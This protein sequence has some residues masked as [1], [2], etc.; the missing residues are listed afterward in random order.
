LFGEGAD[1]TEVPDGGYGRVLAA[2]EGNHWWTGNEIRGVTDD[3]PVAGCGR[4][5]KWKGD[6]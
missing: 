2:G 5:R 4:G 3:I 1:G 6:E